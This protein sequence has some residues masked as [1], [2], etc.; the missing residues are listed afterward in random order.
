MVLA[1]PI[2]P[3]LQSHLHSSQLKTR[4]EEEGFANDLHFL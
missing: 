3:C 4:E 2:V 1:N